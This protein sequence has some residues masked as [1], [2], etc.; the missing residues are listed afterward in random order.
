MVYL[1]WNNEEF[2][3]LLVK[4]GNID[5]IKFPSVT[6]YERKLFIFWRW[7]IVAYIQG[8]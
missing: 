1:L 7:A 6:T 5:K 4:F 3:K 8:V 2:V